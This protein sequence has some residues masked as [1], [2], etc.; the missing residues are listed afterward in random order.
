LVLEIPP[1]FGS[2]IREAARKNDFSKQ[3]LST[4]LTLQLRYEPE[5][6]DHKRKE[7]HECKTP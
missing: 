1:H 6:Q 3:H 5:N 2:E 7:N 4:V